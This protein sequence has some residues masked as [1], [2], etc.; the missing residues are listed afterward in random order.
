MSFAHND[1]SWDV[2]SPEATMLSDFVEFIL[3]YSLTIT[4]KAFT[5]LE[6]PTKLFYDLFKRIFFSQSLN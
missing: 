3:F 4:T 5:P 6:S 1:H 2:L